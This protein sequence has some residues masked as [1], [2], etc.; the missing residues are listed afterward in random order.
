MKSRFRTLSELRQSLAI[1]LGF[2]AQAGV[3]DLQIP[4]LNEQLQS[5]QMQIWREIAFRYL[6]KK[7]EETLGVGQK[8]LD[9][10]DDNPLGKL[11]GIYLL[12]GT[13]W[14]R[15]REG[16]PRQ[17]G[18]QQS[19][20]NCFELTAREEGDLQIE[21]YPVPEKLYQ[22]RVE[23]YASPKRFTQNNDRASLPDDLILTLATV[24]AKGHY[25]QPD[26]Q[27]YAD[28]YDRIMRDAKA[29]NFGADGEFSDGGTD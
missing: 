26:V 5:A 17:T 1:L 23:Y 8:V 16:I 27:M 6:Q 29:Q 7:H 18:N 14:V 19:Q 13:R 28:K 20:P 15:L 3:I 9:L 12:D 11:Y 22:I 25:R 21:L 10:P 4:F 24:F 2:G